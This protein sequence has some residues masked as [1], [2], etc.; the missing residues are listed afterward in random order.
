MLAVTRGLFDRAA[1]SVTN[2]TACVIISFIT[3]WVRLRTHA[4][5]RA[6]LLLL[7][8]KFVMNIVS[9]IKVFKIVAISELCVSIKAAIVKRS[10]NC[11]F[12]IM[13]VDKLAII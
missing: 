10:V 2:K 3:E 9:I 6:L 7:L 4:P 11:I 8:E 13:S 5:N 12:P 1:F